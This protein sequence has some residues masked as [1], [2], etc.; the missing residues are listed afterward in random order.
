[1]AAVS[2]R[3][4]QPCRR[5]SAA[6]MRRRA[7]EASSATTGPTTYLPAKEP[8]NRVTDRLAVAKKN[9]RLADFEKA[10]E[11][12]APLKTRGLPVE[13]RDGVE[14]RRLHRA[15]DVGRGRL[16]PAPGDALI[17]VD[18]TGRPEAAALVQRP[19][20]RG[21]VEENGSPFRRVE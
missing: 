1:M 3:T 7:S 11:Q 14:V 2:M 6:S 10:P 19:A 4:K 18:D 20:L 15:D 16:V 5:E 12:R 17:L 8:G 13:T 21:G 9:L